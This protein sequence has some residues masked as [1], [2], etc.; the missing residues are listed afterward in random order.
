MTPQDGID[1]A[2]QQARRLHRRFG[3]ESQQHVDVYAFANRLNV[4]LVDAPLEGALAQLIVNRGSARILLSSQLR[5]P[6][7]RRIAIA[8]EL[9]HY[10]LSHPSATV[11]ELC[12]PGQPQAAAFGRDYENEA[13][14]F[15]LE[16]LMLP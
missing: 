10:V 14:S 16:L 1:Q 3:V 7:R 15:A 5:D 6:T 4:Q 11:G 9:G 12:E 2:R 8:H 13:H